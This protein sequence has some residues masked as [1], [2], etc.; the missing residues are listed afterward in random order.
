MAWM[1]LLSIPCGC[2]AGPSRLGGALGGRPRARSATQSARAGFTGTRGILAFRRYLGR[3][4]GAYL[5]RL[6]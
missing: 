1:L 2:T 6:A 3:T 5:G 4:P